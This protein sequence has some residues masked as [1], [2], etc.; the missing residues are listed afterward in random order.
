MSDK[1]LYIRPQDSQ[2]AGYYGAPRGHRTHNGVDI[3]CE[4]LEEVKSLT[5]GKV[6][7][8]GFPYD[9]KHP[10]KGHLRYVEVEMDG[11]KFRYFYIYPWV[12]KGDKVSPS[13]V[14]G[15]SQDLTKIYKGITQ[16]YHL[17]CKDVNDEYYNPCD[18]FPFIKE[19]EDE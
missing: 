17:E 4:S 6:T 12:K 11:N 2:G 19:K 18:K 14:L 13:T 8:I 9:P 3:C 5:L 1:V 7:K 10:V 16:H 15:T